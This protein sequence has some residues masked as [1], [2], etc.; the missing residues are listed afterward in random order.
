[1]R[2]QEHTLTPYRRH[3]P[4]CP[5][6]KAS[7]L[8]CKCPLWAHGRVKGRLFRR[9]LGT[10][11]L[12]KA[13]EKINALLNRKEAE[14]A[15]EKPAPAPKI[16]DAIKDYLHYCKHNKRLKASTLVSYRDTLQAF[17]AFSAE[18]L[19]RTVDQINPKLFELWQAERK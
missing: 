1:M 18:R 4:D 2:F 17:E 15:P 10:R 13:M 9:S 11:S 12:Q 3:A 8:K 7:E 16:S 14:P 5:L 6:T 19:F